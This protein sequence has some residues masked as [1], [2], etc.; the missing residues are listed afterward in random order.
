MTPSVLRNVG[1]FIFF[2]KGTTAVKTLRGTTA[3][4]T[5]TWTSTSAT[6]DS[7]H[8]FGAGDTSTAKKIK[9][10]ILLRRF[11]SLAVGAGVKLTFKSTTGKY[12]VFTG[13]IKTCSSTSGAG[14]TWETLSTATKTVTNGTSTAFSVWDQFQLSADLQ[15]GKRFLKSNIKI[16]FKTATGGKDTTTNTA[17]VIMPQSWVFGG[18]TDTPAAGY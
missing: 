12:V 14:S 8:G 5:G 13:A 7:I 6:F 16:A 1:H 9:G 15:R 11:R 18:P 4:D 3:T 17:A 2:W 10:G